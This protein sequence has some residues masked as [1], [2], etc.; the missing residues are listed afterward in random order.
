M[1]LAARALVGLALVQSLRQ[2]VR[3]A[4]APK[5]PSTSRRRLLGGAAAACALGAFSR[6]AAATYGSSSAAV[7][8]PAPT[9][10][11]TVEQFEKLGAKKLKQ[12]E[13]AL[14]P[15]VV[16]EILEELEASVAD[17][18]R[19]TTELGDQIS[20]DQSGLAKLFRPPE[21]RKDDALKELLESVE[22]EKKSRE[23]AIAKIIST[24]DEL[25]QQL[26]QRR[27]IEAELKK[28][29]AI[30]RKLDAQPAWVSY[31]A[32]ALASCVSTSIMHPVDTIKTRLQANKAVDTAGPDAKRSPGGPSLPL[33]P[34]TSNATDGGGGG[35]AVGR[36]HRAS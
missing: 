32:A 22:A 30:L 5:P 25:V 23:A 31:A 2:P 1:R 34:L 19:Q 7:T 8:S 3:M 18:A 15:R 10:R 4:A 14:G 17:L 36:G 27:Q 20:R 35:G 28:R 24:K 12:R 21:A 29:A 26:E 6:P 16:D 11:L 9:K 13:G 33:E